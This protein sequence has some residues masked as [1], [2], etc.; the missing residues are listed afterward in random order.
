MCFWVTRNSRRE[1][2]KEKYSLKWLKVRELWRSQIK[3]I[4]DTPISARVCTKSCSSVGILLWLEVLLSLQES[5][6]SLPGLCCS[7]RGHG[8]PDSERSGNHTPFHP[9]HWYWLQRR[10]NNRNFKKHQQQGIVYGTTNKKANLVQK[11][12]L[13][14]FP[15]INI[16]LKVNLSPYSQKAHPGL[17]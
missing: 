6:P 5:P 9:S 16:A 13:L 14:S 1:M 10:R 15:L 7:C 12:C 17:L 3:Q 2:I 4:Y 8:P 11:I